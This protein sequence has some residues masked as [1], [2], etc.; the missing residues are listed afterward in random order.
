MSKTTR[1]QNVMWPN[2]LD[3]LDM[4]G[5]VETQPIYDRAIEK[6]I[7]GQHYKHLAIQPA[8]YCQRNKLNYME[9][10]AIKYITRWQDKGGLEDIDKAIHCLELLK[11]F[12]S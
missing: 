4:S 12:E 11:E 2:N 10:S 3:A 7:G 6:Q 9:S 5:Y 8:E 1:K